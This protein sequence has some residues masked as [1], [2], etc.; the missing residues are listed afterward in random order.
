MTKKI[1]TFVGLTL[2]VTAITASA[3]ISQQIRVNVPFSFVVGKRISPPGD[4]R[5]NVD[6]GRE[7]VTFRAPDSMTTNLFMPQESRSAD[8]RTYL[9]FRRYGEQW[10]L[11][12]V[13]MDGVTQK[14]LLGK[15]ER[16]MIAAT[17]RD[18]RVIAADLTFHK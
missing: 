8:G 15:A 17:S 12:E 18:T 9:T 6:L 2:L 5:V 14:V 4:Y 10:F 7:L 1:R 16:M 3:Q 13:T 11:Q